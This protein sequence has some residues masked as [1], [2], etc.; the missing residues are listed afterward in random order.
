M[1]LHFQ[2]L[3]VAIQCDINLV[4]LTIE[5]AIVAQLV[6]HAFVDTLSKIFQEAASFADYRHNK[7][8][9]L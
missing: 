4:Y 1:P 2:I 3:T 7:P 9:S 5:G 8:D 6:E